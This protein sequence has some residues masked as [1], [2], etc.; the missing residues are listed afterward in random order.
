MNARAPTLDLAAFARVLEAHGLGPAAERVAREHGVAVGELLHHAAARADLFRAMAGAGFASWAI[1]L[2]TGTGEHEV[3]KV[4][5]EPL[6][7]QGQGANAARAPVDVAPSTRATRSRRAPAPRGPRGLTTPRAPAAEGDQALHRWISAVR[8]P[9]LSREEEGA[10]VL[11]WQERGDLAARERVVRANLLFVVSRC[12][13]LAAMSKV[14]L[15]DLVAEGVCGLLRALDTFEPGR[16]SLRTYAAAWIWKSITRHADATRSLVK[17]Q[18]PRLR[19]VARQVSVA[20]ARLEAEHG[21]GAAVDAG[22]L[23]KFGQRTLDFLEANRVRLGGEASLDAPMGDDADCT[24]HDALASSWL[25]A[26]EL[27]AAREAG[28]ATTATIERALAVLRPTEREVIRRRRL[29]EEPETLEQIGDSMGVSR[30]RVGQIE[31]KA[32]KKLREALAD[33]REAG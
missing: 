19:A 18:M 21:P 13:R 2:T 31:A 14:A 15:D 3:E 9:G 6:R 33:A 1:A 25:G 7:L 23:A 22:L 27:V 30:A 32:M 10:L 16:A 26:D 28:D 8:T 20:R 4:L 5:A 17:T 24:L 11:A 12:A 29:T